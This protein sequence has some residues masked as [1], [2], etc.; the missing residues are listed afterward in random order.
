M[1]TDNNIREQIIDAGCWVDEHLVLNSGRHSDIKIDM[2][3]LLA[4]GAGNI[5]RLR[6][7][8]NPI[9]AAMVANTFGTSGYDSMVPV[10]NG[11]LEL[12]AEVDTPENF[13]PIITSRKLAKREFAFRHPAAPQVLRNAGRIAVFDDVITTGGTPLAMAEAIRATGSQAELDLYAIW[14]RGQL[15]PEISQVFAHQFYLIE[16][17]IPTWPAE[18]C[19]QCNP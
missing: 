8:M 4:P 11:A 14:R 3:K 1:A 19:R 2:E 7:V 12:A 18:A 17:E 13:P 5:M 9:A 10:P 15:V 6:A 16:E